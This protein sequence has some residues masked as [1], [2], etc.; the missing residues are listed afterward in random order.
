M[1]VNKEE[2]CATCTHPSCYRCPLAI[3]LITEPCQPRYEEATAP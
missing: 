1:D 2:G 3:I